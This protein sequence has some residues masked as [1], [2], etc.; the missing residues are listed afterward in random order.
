ME[1]IQQEKI[2]IRIR[3]I[4]NVNIIIQKNKLNT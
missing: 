4:L 2:I 1:W 3:D